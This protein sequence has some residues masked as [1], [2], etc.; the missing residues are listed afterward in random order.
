M[1][2]FIT[3]SSTLPFLEQ[4]ANSV[5]FCSAK[6]YL[7][8]QWGL[9]WKRKYPHTQNRKNNSGNLH[10]DV[11]IQPTELHLYF[12][13]LLDS[14]V[15][16]ESEKWYFRYLW[17]LCGQRKRPPMKN[18]KKLSEK[19]LFDLWIPL[20]ELQLSSQKQFANTLYVESAK[21]DLG[22][23]RGPWWKRISD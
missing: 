20:T 13:G 8:V 21:W 18:R 14:P 16:E 19:L 7:R 17:R 2:D 10:F 6:W 11:W 23:H 5:I 3:P 1:C 4:F 9:W 15:S 22:A 12:V